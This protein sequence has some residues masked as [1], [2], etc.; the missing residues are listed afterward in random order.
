[1]AVACIEGQDSI[2]GQDT[3]VDQGTAVDPGTAEDPDTAGDLDTAEAHAYWAVD[4]TAV[5]S[6]AVALVE[7][8]SW[9]S[10]SAT[11]VIIHPGEILCRPAFILREVE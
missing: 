11:V 8:L 2:E 9:C 6:T 5:D 3:A 7:T 1:M 4:H 10:C